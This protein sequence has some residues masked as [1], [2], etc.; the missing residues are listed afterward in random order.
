MRSR[1]LRNNEFSIQIEKKGSCRFPT[2][3]PLMRM[4]EGGGWRVVGEEGQKQ[5]KMIK[6]A[7]G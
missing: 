4:V 7:N 5:G 2:F 6:V 1:H 3:D